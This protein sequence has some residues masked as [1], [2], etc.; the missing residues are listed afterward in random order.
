MRARCVITEHLG[1][2]RK[3]P[4]WSTEATY[5]PGSTAGVPEERR[6]AALLSAGALERQSESAQDLARLAVKMWACARKAAGARLVSRFYCCSCSV[7]L[8]LPRAAWRCTVH[9]LCRRLEQLGASLSPRG[10]PPPSA[11]PCRRFSCFSRSAISAASSA[12]RRALPSARSGYTQCQQRGAAPLPSPVL[13]AA[14]RP[15]L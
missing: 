7:C 8:P 2:R 12:Q 3:S 5:L 10:T 1:D 11:P 15:G 13:G 6:S 14:D 4:V 9:A